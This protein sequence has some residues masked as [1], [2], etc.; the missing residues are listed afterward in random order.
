[1]NKITE[2]LS[3]GG[4][5]GLAVNGTEVNEYIKEQ[6]AIA[7]AEQLK[8]P[9]PKWYENIPEHGV[10]CWVRRE[11]G[12]VKKIA[13]IYKYH[14]HFGFLAAFYWV[15]KSASVIPLT[16]EEIEGFKR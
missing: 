8:Q 3:V 14:E 6:V 11:L 13:T 9:E 5:K 16:N 12:G 1:M 4:S 15:D 2:I 10:W 7:I